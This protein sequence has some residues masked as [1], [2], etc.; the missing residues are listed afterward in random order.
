MTVAVPALSNLDPHLM[1]EHIGKRNELQER[2]NLPGPVEE[3]DDSTA[4]ANSEM[5]PFEDYKPHIEKVLQDIGLAGFSV[6]ALQHGYSYQNCVYA[7]GS[8]TDPEERY[9]LRVPQLPEFREIDGKC[10]AIENDAAVLG[11][12]NGKLPV[13]RVKVFGSSNKNA[14]EQPYTIQS[15]LPGMSLNEV[16]D[17]LSYEEKAGIVDQFV[18]LLAK[19]ESVHFETAGSFAAS[20][21]E[22]S[23]DEDVTA[24]DLIIE[25]FDEGDDKFVKGSSVAQDRAGTDLKL[26]FQSHINGWIAQEVKKDESFSID[27]LR[28]FLAM[29]E[30][31]DKEGAF[32]NASYPIVLHHWDLEP[33][34]IMVENISGVWEIT[35]LIDWDDAVALP[36]PLARR[37]PDW[38]WDFDN[39]GFTGYLNNDHHP[40]PD[41]KLSTENLAL[42]AHFDAKAAAVL[43]GYLED[44]YGY[45]LWLRRIWTFARE[46]VNS[47][48]Y[49]DLAKELEEDWNARPKPELLSMPKKVSR[50]LLEEARDWFFS[51]E[52][53][54]RMWL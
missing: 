31:L 1:E 46:G 6:E 26:L 14:L 3:E 30:E 54:L 43:D 20:S 15:R 16:Y 21:L 32:K 42:K 33:R 4:S 7:L 11:F 13:P 50:G 49:I 34:N 47:I 8:P 10:E 18:E 40:K 19:V 36:R 48:W 17:D 44:A 5:E 51:L 35:G 24:P 45:G 28:F 25:C 2:L 29:I 39:E 41:H 22:P 9:V 12:L 53:V 52:L 27:S 37:A 38:I 23:D